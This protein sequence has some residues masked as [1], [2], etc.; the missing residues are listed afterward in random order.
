MKQRFSLIYVCMFLIIQLNAQGVEGLDILLK[1]EKDTYQ[2]LEPWNFTVEVK[3]VGKADCAFMP[4][5]IISGQLSEASYIKLEIKNKNHESWVE[6]KSIGNWCHSD[7][8]PYFLQPGEFV[9]YEFTC[10]PALDQLET[11]SNEFRIAYAPHCR[12]PKSMYAY[13]NPVNLKV[14]DYNDTRNAM[15]YN[16]LLKLDRPDFLLSP[17]VYISRDTSD[18]KHAEYVV[19]RFPTSTLAE[20]ANLYLC[21]E[22]SVRAHYSATKKDKIRAVEHLR[23]S[24]K[25]GILALQSKNPLIV[26][27]VNFTLAGLFNIALVV[28]DYNV[29]D[30]I[31]SEFE[32]YPGQ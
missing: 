2:L 4:T 20:Y 31:G 6:T 23:S 5:K 15:V 16:Y 17:V 29:P 7:Y 28:Y 27:K 25:Y 13:S 10:S 19:N 9:T 30:E 14:L 24:K 32:Y 1:F 21:F 18:I 11:G 3:N 22:Y 8:Q 26:A 12:V